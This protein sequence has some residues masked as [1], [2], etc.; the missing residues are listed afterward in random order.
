MLLDKLFVTCVIIVISI[1]V[2]HDCKYHTELD[3][4][5][6]WGVHLVCGGRKKCLEF[7]CLGLDGPV[8]GGPVPLMRI[9]ASPGSQ[10]GVHDN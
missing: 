6:I 8:V 1:L 4:L 3:A 5:L 9:V 7:F 10:L 2:K